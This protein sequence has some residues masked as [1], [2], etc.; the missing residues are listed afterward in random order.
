MAENNQSRQIELLIREIQRL[1]KK[2][3]R[4]EERLNQKNRTVFSVLKQRGFQLIRS[5]PTGGLLLPGNAGAEVEGRFYDLM[6]RYSFRLFLRDLIL[7]KD[8]IHIKHLNRYCCNRTASQYI[9]LLTEMGILA[10]MGEDTFALKTDRIT[11]FGPTLEWFIAQVFLR[12]FDA[13]AIYNVK[14]KETRF[15]GD[16]DVIARLDERLCYIEVKSSPPKGI[17]NTDVRSFL[18]R[19][20]DLT[21][22]VAFFFVDTELRMKDKIVPLFEQEIRHVYGEAK[23]FPLPALRLKEELFRINDNLF[24]MNSK[25]GVVTNFRTCLRYFATHRRDEQAFPGWTQ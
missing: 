18:Y 16:F 19:L 13:P 1:E 17:E 14:F 24:I 22:D 21:P 15:G 6:R 20:G 9:R 23:A 4:L 8:H 10:L 2:V 25:K 7:H 5:N 11:S 12:E 3:H